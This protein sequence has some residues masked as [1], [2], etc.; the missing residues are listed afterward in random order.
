MYLS[1]KSNKTFAKTIPGKL[2]T[3]MST[4]K[5]IIAS[6]SGETSKIIKKAN[7]G[8]TSKAEN[9]KELEKIILTFLKLDKRKKKKLGKNGKSYADKNFNKS[10]ILQNLSVEV[11][12]LI[13]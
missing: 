5:P 11:N 1:L 12:K 7:C 13:I 6:I 8:L 2:Q 9:S 4:S 3:Y 10:K